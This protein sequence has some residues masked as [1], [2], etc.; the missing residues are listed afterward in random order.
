LGNNIRLSFSD[1]RENAEAKTCKIK[2]ESERGK[3]CL[4]Y[5]WERNQLG[6]QESEQNNQPL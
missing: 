3:A 6:V 5:P 4:L 1:K 2:R